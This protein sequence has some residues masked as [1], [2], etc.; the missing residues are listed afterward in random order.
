MTPRVT[1]P[2]GGR[3]IEWDKKALS[4]LALLGARGVRHKDIAV[5]LGTTLSAVDSRLADLRHKG[6]P[7]RHNKRSPK[8]GE[9]IKK[10]LPC[11]GCGKMMNTIIEIRQC[12]ACKNL[13]RYK[14]GLW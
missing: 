9:E 3:R 1:N 7:R 5:V 4:T 8:L 11:L 13:Y 14:C 2:Y 10:D 6:T 12:E